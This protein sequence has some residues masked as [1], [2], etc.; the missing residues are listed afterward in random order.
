M[1]D[2]C[3]SLRNCCRGLCPDLHGKERRV[4]KPSLMRA[5]AWPFTY[6][7][8]IIQ[9]QIKVWGVIEN[10]VVSVPVKG[11]NMCSPES[12]S[13]FEI[14]DYVQNGITSIWQYTPPTGLMLL[15]NN[16]RWCHYYINFIP[17]KQVSSLWRKKNWKLWTE[18]WQKLVWGGWWKNHSVYYSAYYFS[19]LK[20]MHHS[21]TQT[22]KQIHV[23]DQSLFR[24]HYCS[25]S[26]N[27]TS[28]LIYI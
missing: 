5:D 27:I 12:R 10:T 16:F 2:L 1:L 15:S 17:P 23:C 19:M 26:F 6:T 21:H 11:R 14:K 4:N 24:L 3:R 9:E 20:C 7:F 8:L 18:V 13:T 25:K 22:N 28:K